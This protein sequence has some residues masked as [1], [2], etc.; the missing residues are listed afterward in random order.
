M[1]GALAG[2]RFLWVRHVSSRTYG[3]AC[4]KLPSNPT[5]NGTY[6]ELIAW[7]YHIFR[8]EPVLRRRAFYQ[9]A[10][11]ASFSSFWTT[12]TFL[13]AGPFHFTQTQIGF[14]ALAGAAGAIVAP[15][16]GSL[17]TG[18]TSAPQPARH[19]SLP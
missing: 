1:A 13:L 6:R 8:H 14:F 3:S 10:M 19:S 5:F 16:A 2:A 15:L 17:A 7:L 18:V 11:F 9:T 12:I 4:E